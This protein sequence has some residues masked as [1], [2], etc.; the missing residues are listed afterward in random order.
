MAKHSTDHQ[1][2]EPAL[3]HREEMMMWGNLAHMRGNLSA[4]RFSAF[5]APPSGGSCIPLVHSP[6]QAASRLA[7][8]HGIDASAAGL[9]GT[10]P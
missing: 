10:G 8:F 1:T 3:T 2:G 6:L 4:I 5:G 7:R 9:G